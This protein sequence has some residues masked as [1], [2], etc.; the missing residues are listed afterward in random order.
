MGWKCH[1]GQPRPCHR[2]ALTFPLPQS[3]APEDAVRKKG[4]PVSCGHRPQAG[5]PTSASCSTFPLAVPAAI[6][7]LFKS[8]G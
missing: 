4:R 2:V 6:R 1:L 5:G 3:Q 7:M 8:K